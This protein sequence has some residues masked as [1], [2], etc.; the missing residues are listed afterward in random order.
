MIRP[1]KLDA[2]SKVYSIYLLPAF[3]HTPI[4]INELSS[5]EQGRHSWGA[6]GAQAP[7]KLGGWKLRILQK[8][9]L[10]PPYIH[11]ILEK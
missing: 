4:L 5:Y 7:P 2:P 8:G 10:K 6:Q 9:G 1:I 3:M 11:H